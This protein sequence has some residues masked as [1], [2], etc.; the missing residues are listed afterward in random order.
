MAELKKKLLRNTAEISGMGLN[1]HG[2]HGNSLTTTKK[3]ACKEGL[4]VSVPEHE[5]RGIAF[6]SQIYAIC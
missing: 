5:E 2:K 3:I 6:K 4:N 1:K